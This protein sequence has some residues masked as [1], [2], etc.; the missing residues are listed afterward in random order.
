MGRQSKDVYCSHFCQILKG[1]H[2]NE[3][4]EN[5]FYKITKKHTLSEAYTIKETKSFWNWK[6][7]ES[8]ISLLLFKLG[9][10]KLRKAK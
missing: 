10:Q 3:T 6:I 1:V 2:I 7:L 5:R 8:I 4:F 9:K